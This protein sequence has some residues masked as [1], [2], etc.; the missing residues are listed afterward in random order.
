M[1]KPLAVLVVE[2]SEDDTRLLER[3]LRLGGYDVARKRVETA[4]AM[5]SALRARAWDLVIADYT[6][7]TF[8]APAALAVVQESGLD[9]PFIIVSGTVGEKAAVEA[10]KAG[11]HDYLLKGSFARLVPAVNR[12]LEHASQRRATRK[13]QEAHA[14]LAAI[15]ESS[16][17]AIIGRNFD[18]TV[19]AWNAGAEKLY[20]YSAEEVLGRTM[21]LHVPADRAG[22]I[23]S[24]V[25]KIRRKEIVDSFETVRIRKDG[26]RIDVSLAVSPIRSGSGEVTGASTI[27]RDINGR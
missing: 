8:S 13:A 10:M 25:E 16:A 21:G 2:D 6:L 27:A 26:T 17:D 7:P 23:R 22:E 24:Y 15:V 9:L 18:G 12:E 20:G 3:E 1:S 19:T 14:Q 5:R 11:A 4:E